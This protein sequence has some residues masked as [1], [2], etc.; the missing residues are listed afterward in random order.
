MINFSEIKSKL[1]QKKI[2]KKFKVGKNTIEVYSIG[3]EDVEKLYEYLAEIYDTETSEF[4][5]ETE[6]TVKYVY[7]TF[8]NIKVEE[9]SD[10]IEAL[11]SPNSLLLDIQREITKSMMEVVNTY[12]KDR[13]VELESMELA[14]TTHDLKVKGDNLVAKYGVDK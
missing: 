12:L 10:L 2:R 8:T 14:I 9:A 4:K 6:E 1:I 7:E 5:V 11:K 3:I 13:V